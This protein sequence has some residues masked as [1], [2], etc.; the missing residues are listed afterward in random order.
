[1]K[2]Y[3]KFIGVLVYFHAIFWVFN[4]VDAWIGI[5]M[6]VLFIG[7]TIY[8]INNNYLKTKKDEKP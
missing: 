4:H 5:L 8:S 1:M 3:L 7:G 2:N 6:G